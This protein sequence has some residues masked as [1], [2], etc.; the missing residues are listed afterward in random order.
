MSQSAVNYEKFSKYGCKIIL[1]EHKGVFWRL[2]KFECK[3][4]RPVAKCLE[5]FLSM[6]EK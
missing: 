2:R 6:G 4:L 5:K 1:V 3:F